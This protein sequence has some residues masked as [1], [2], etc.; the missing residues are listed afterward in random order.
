VKIGKLKS[1]LYGIN[2]K[3]VSE[4]A[5]EMVRNNVLMLYPYLAEA[6]LRGFSYTEELRQIFQRT[7]KEETFDIEVDDVRS[8][9]Y[10]DLN[11][12][13]NGDDE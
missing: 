12:V 9:V 1:S 8:L 5:S 4:K 3:Y 11:N 2:E 7:G 6:M 10:E 13:E